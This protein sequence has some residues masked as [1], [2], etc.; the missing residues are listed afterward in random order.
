MNRSEHYQKLLANIGKLPKDRQEALKFQIE[1]IQSRPEPTLVEKA[2]NF[3]KA[4]TKHVIKG[5]RNVPEDVQK[6]R[7]DTCKGCEHYNP[8]KDSCRLC[9]CKMSVKTGWSEQECPINLWTAWSK[10]SSPPEP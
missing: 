6:A 1:S 10:P 8:E 7:Y 3:T 2:K 9:G 5:F 4:V